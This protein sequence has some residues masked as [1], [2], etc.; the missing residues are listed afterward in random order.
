MR[1]TWDEY[2]LQIAQLV[3]TRATCLRRQHGAV[4]VSDRQILATGY[5]GAPSGSS[6]CDKCAREEAGCLPGQ[7]YEI[8]RSVHAEQNAVA[9][10][11]KHGVKTAGAT[12]YITGPPCKMCA[13]LIV[14]AGIAQ[15]KF[16]WSSVYR[17][18]DTGLDILAEAGVQVTTLEA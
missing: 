18:E 1:P 13:R 15:V 2:F 10:A 16:A 17:M 11:A 8:C 7:R 4:L 9:Q 12:L 14:N 3:S 5:N 6:H